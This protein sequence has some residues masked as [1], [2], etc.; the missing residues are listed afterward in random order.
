MNFLQVGICSLKMVWKFQKVLILI[1]LFKLDLQHNVLF[2]RTK[3]E[4]TGFY[5]VWHILENR[6]L[7]YWKTE[8]YYVVHL[9]HHR[10]EAS[11]LSF[12][13]NCFSTQIC[14]TLNALYVVVAA[15]CWDESV[16]V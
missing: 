8:F 5:L 2:C 7:P 10:P 14:M 11:T 9:R 15:F 13:C 16:A 6:L 3:C 12:E 1:F 4:K